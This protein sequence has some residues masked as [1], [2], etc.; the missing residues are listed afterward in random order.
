LIDEMRAITRRDIELSFEN[1]R[2][3]DQRW[4][5]ANTAAA[6][7]ALDLPKRRDWRDGVAR[8][9]EWLAAERGLE[10]RPE[11]ASAAE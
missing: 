10:L 8:L 6:Q 9:A 11:L 5:V 1:W 7:A 4:F 2:Q 3:G